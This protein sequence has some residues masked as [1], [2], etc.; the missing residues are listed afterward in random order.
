MSSRVW[1]Y[2]S[3][4]IQYPKGEVRIAGG[5]RAQSG[6]LKGMIHDVLDKVGERGD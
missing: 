5:I 4:L 3:F 1:E 2:D 6:L